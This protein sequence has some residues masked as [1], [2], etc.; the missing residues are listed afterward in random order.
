[1]KIHE[2]GTYSGKFTTHNVEPM[3]MLGWSLPSLDPD[4]WATPLLAAGEPVANFESDKVNKMIT[5]ARGT[6]DPEKRVALYRDFNRAVH[7]E[8]PWLFLHQQ[9]DLY[10]TSAGIRWKARSD[11]SINLQEISLN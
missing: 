5:E 3:Y 8:A 1:V 4:H 11:E 2:W 9:I 6:L 7:E 10:G